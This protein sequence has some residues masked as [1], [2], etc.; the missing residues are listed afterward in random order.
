[1]S[2]LHIVLAAALALI[3]TT[4]QAAPNDAARL[5]A[6]D[7]WWGHIA[8]LAA[9]DM[10]GRL[11]GSSGYDKAAAYVEGQFKALGLAPAGIDG[12]RQPVRFG[13]QKVLADQSSV[14]L[15]ADGIATPLAIG[16]Q[17]ILSARLPQPEAIEAPLVFIGYGLHLP[18]AGEDDFAGQN[19]KGKIAVFINGGPDDIAAALKSH[20]RAA[21]TWKAVEKAGALGLITIPL[22]S[23]MDI[24]WAR[25]ILLSSQAG[26][27]LADADMQDAKGPR[28]T[29][30]VNP[31]AAEA[32]FA[33]SG[34]SFK[35]ILAL[36][37]AH[38]RFAGFPLNLS[39][40][41]HVATVQTS[42]T[43]PNLIAKL[44]G[45]DPRLKDQYVVI[46][47][48]LD[49]LGVGAPINGD[50]IYHGAMDDASGVA[51]I[52]EI[53]R[54]LKE[55]GAKPRRT[56]LFAVVT[57]EE[58]GLLG[59]HYFALHPT[60]PRSA[61]V[62]D[63]NMDMPL[64]LWPLHYVMVQGLNE[65]T[66]GGDAKAVA[67]AHGYETTLDPYPDRNSFIRTDQYSFVRTGVPALAFKFGWAPNSAEQATEK[68]WRANRYHSPAD[69]LT[70]PIDKP[71]AADF[72]Q[73]MA[74]LALRVADEDQTPSWLETSFF[75]R[76]AVK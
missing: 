19:L 70:Q 63:L 21:E 17:I 60:V 36:A 4:V 10:Q 3:S 37:E 25:Q 35:D 39:L 54:T 34:H 18:E 52:L 12:Y 33:H 51:S 73:Y 53:A 38:K 11:T 32:L 76:F 57:G 49:H 40:R 69:N 62:A 44:E 13:V 55:T 24:P 7:R 67:A 68:A 6:G 46:S 50:P 59:S 72:D 48:H 22:P 2:K 28:F 1:M 31:D 26:M 61:I 20:S 58:K 23:G 75:K 71:A 15:V 43:S 56:I 47:A 74:D 14:A 9:D 66:L 45:S 65:S 8:V 5:A 16:P 30:S 27:Y 42:V 64:P 29:A 41:A